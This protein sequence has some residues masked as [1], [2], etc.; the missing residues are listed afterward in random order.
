MIEWALTE[1][2]YELRMSQEP[3]NEIGTAMLSALE[4]FLDQVETESAHALV[5][6]ST[7]RGG[8]SA[9]ADP[10]QLYDRLRRPPARAPEGALREV[11]DR[12]QPALARP[13]I[14]PATT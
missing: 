1:G 8:V 14:R 3:C 9:G 13:H 12:L 6:R 7:V 11:L 2:V 10:R 5:I 4:R